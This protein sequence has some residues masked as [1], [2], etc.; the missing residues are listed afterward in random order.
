MTVETI[1]LAGGCFWGLEAYFKK[2]HG[3]VAVESGYANGNTSVPT[4]QDVID[5]SGHAETIK[6]SYD[7]SQISLSDI[8]TYYF[9][10]ID[11]TS[12]NQ[13]G[14][15]KGIQYRTGIYF[16]DTAQ[17]PIIEQAI[18]EEQKKWY[19]PIVVEVLP[20]ANYSKAEE[21]HQS[22]LLKNPQG[23]CHIPLG[24]ADRPLVKAS[25]YHKPSAEEIRQRL[26][27]EAYQITQHAGTERAF[28]NA[29]WDFFAQGLYVDIISAEPLFS[30]K[31]KFPSQCGWPSFT[32]PI[33]PEVL[34][35]Y[36]DNSH[37][38]QR[39]EVRSRVADAHLGHVFEDGPRET[40]GLRYCINGAALR[41]IPLEKMDEEGYGV[42]KAYC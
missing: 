39:I 32:R 36:Q 29:Y 17:L 24:L 15:D 4:Y 3:V 9:R 42:F 20:L 23:Y 8:L 13:Q 31:D 34:R 27:D 12:L 30:S 10:V 19:K 22:Y 33:A 21:Y 25:L 28:S 11:P 7:P 6:L 2:I 26:S 35:Y 40:G 16:T 41:F 37:G 38:M 14:N 5:G 1:Y 18:Q